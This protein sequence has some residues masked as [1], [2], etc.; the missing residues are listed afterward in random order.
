MANGIVLHLDTTKSEF[1][2]PM[3]ELRQGDGNY[4]SLDITVTS[5]GEPFDLT[6]WTINFMGTTAGGFKI[7]DDAINVTN[8][9]QG[10]FTYTPTKA[11]GQDEGEFK[12]AYFSF[13]KANQ[14]ASSAAFR[15]NVLS[16]VDLTAEEAGDYIS[17]VD[18]TI[19]Q[20]TSDLSSLATSVNDL[21][22]QNLGIKTSDN[23]W[24]GTNTFNKQIT[25]SFSTRGVTFTDFATVAGNMNTYSGQWRVGSNVVANSPVNNMTYYLI[26]VI[27]DISGTAGIIRVAQYGNSSYYYNVVNAGVLTTWN[28]VAKDE[29]VVHNSGNETIGGSKTFSS[30][31]NG[32][33]NGNS[34]TATKLQTARKIGGVTFDGSGDINLPGVNAT[35]NQSTTG[36]AAT[37]TKLQFARTINGTAFDGTSDITITGANALP[38]AGVYPTLADLVTANP[39]HSFIYVTTDN[40]NWNY[41][42]VTSSSWA[43]GGVYQA[44]GISDASITPQKLVT[45][46]VPVNK[47]GKTYST[48]SPSTTL[49]IPNQL[50]EKSGIVNVSGNFGSGNV[51]LFL[52]KKVDDTYVVM[53][54][55]NKTAVN[56][57]QTFVTDFFVEGKGDEY[58]GVMGFVKYNNAGGTGFYGVNSANENNKV[59]T[60]ATFT[61]NYDLSVFPTFENIKLAQKIETL[62]NEINGKIVEKTTDGGEKDFATYDVA[63]V[64]KKNYINNSA[65]HEGNI[66]VHVAITTAQTGKLYILEK[67]GLNFTVKK[68]KDVNFVAGENVVDMEYTAS[69]S[70]N[71]YIGYFGIGYFKRSGGLGFYEAVPGDYIKGDT[72]TATDNTSGTVGVYDLA[73][74]AEYSRVSLKTSIQSL[75][76]KIDENDNKIVDLISSIKLTDYTMPK[77]SEVSGTVGFVGRWF[78]TTIGGVPVKATINEGSELYFKVKNTTTINVNFVLNSVKATPFFAYSIDGSPMT[79][80]LITSPL[81]PTVTTD[82]HIVRV[83][84]DG[85][86]ESEDK[87][88]GEK[89]VAFKD[90]TVDAGGVVTG[91]A[92]KNRQILFH[93]DSITEGVRVLN[94]NADSTGNSATGA[95]P[96]IASS[97]LNSI[98][99]RVGFGATG[100]TKPGSGGVPELIQVID[101]MTN[102]RQAPYIEPDIVVMNM[103]TNDRAETSAVFTT[104]L[105]SV[106]DRLSIKYSGTPIFVMVPFIQAFKTEIENAVSTR[107]NM[108]IVETAD[109]NITTTDGLHPDLAGG[110]VAGKK[111]AD[112]IKSV[113]G[114]DFFIGQR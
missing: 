15:A 42:N 24:T 13:V 19:D 91:I 30:T 26:E 11:W 106:L 89:G 36:N 68:Y 52:L 103:G 100:V 56:G 31:V 84:I 9:L 59:F 80:Q 69:G 38:V 6:G 54:K 114:K 81:L 64:A 44:T 92:P 94:M 76:E 101:N 90:V 39:E 93:G 65:L 63:S 2:N 104:K 27:P 3:I 85:L 74:Y 18:Q 61:A 107:S 55:V 110:I 7:I 78:D 109:W 95:F 43:A 105:N 20:L 16:A 102:A 82:E 108:Y 86:T 37:A 71:E 14:T 58:I 10:E 4:Q 66:T 60:G 96:Y 57:F 33:L 79:R 22:S 62:D 40:G 88:I 75:S 41:W 67:D 8:A 21:K 12:N 34:T 113:I 70:G 50:L 23:T 46:Y 72:F 112:K 87:W 47:S 77:Y 98:S 97:N 17:I 25:G 5:N 35:G 49:F 73:V 111:L 51:T 45:S 99:Y 1:Q 28:K 48:T 32:N 83:V 53:D 29:T